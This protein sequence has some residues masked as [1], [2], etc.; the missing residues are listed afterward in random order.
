MACWVLSGPFLGLSGVILDHLWP[1]KE[2]RRFCIPY[3]THS[4]RTTVAHTTQTN[5]N[6]ST[7]DQKGIKGLILVI[8]GPYLDH[9]G[10][11]W[12]ILGHWGQTKDFELLVYVTESL[13]LGRQPT[14]TA[15]ANLARPQ[16]NTECPGS[17]CSK[18]YGAFCT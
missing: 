14:E 7:H 2:D 15:S 17:S 5:R 8:C 4:K 1:K 13:Q 10:P 18:A 3:I 12:A 6:S 16:D 9:F 11:F